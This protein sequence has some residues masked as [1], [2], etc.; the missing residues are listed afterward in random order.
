MKT[1]RN[2][3]LFVLFITLV[4][5]L[6]ESCGEEKKRVDTYTAE[7]RMLEDS[8]EM[9]ILLTKDQYF[10]FVPGD[11][12]WIDTDLCRIDEKDSDCMRGVIE[13]MTHS[14]R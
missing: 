2:C 12:V 13:T 9:T 14:W 3:I 4:V 6:C 5:L 7:M 11:S 1:I 10:T 8:T